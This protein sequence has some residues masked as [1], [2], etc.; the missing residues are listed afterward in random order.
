[1]EYAAFT[2]DKVTNDKF[3]SGNYSH[4][5]AINKLRLTNYKKIVAFEKYT[6][7]LSEDSL[8]ALFA[9][10][11]FY[12]KNELFNKEKRPDLIRASLF[13]TYDKFKTPSWWSELYTAFLENDVLCDMFAFIDSA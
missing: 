6:A 9:I 13:F 11:N 4:D 5:S 2:A 7:S 1:M 3:F 10:I 12:L 8:K